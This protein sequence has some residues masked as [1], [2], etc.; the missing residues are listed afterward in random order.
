MREK[1][2]NPPEEPRNSRAAAGSGEP[3]PAR[4]A[5]ILM[6]MEAEDSSAFSWPRWRLGFWCAL[7][8]AVLAAL[9]GV[10]LN[11]A[12]PGEE[13]SPAWRTIVGAAA[14]W[15]AVWTAVTFLPEKRK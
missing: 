1:N 7:I 11:R 9:A 15:V 3:D 4:V 12:F 10:A 2:E 6:R 8:A 13:G 5:E 14:I